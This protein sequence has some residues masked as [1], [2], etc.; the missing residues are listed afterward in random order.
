MGLFGRLEK[1]CQHSC[2][3]PITFQPWQHGHSEFGRSIIY[4]EIQTTQG[5]AP[6]DETQNPADEFGSLTTTD[7]T[8][9]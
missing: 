6:D 8:V 7:P 3:D 2:T 5:R 9:G 4:V 1:A